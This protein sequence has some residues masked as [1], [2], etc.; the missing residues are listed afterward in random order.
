MTGTFL[1]GLAA[2]AA[3]TVALDAV[4]H[5]DMALRGRPAST[6]PEQLVDAVAERI[7]RP[8]PGSGRMRSTLS[9]SSEYFDSCAFS[10]SGRAT[11]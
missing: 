7:G 10:R 2:G 9:D 4:S 3:G 6:V 8:V 11:K 5:L 1:R